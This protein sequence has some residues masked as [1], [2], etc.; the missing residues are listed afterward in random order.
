MGH[1]WLMS[2]MTVPLL[3]KF[4]PYLNVV[5]LGCVQLWS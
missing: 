1:A 2:N 3:P 5:Q 4:S